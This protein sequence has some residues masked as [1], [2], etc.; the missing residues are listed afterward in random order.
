MIGLV[1]RAEA[2]ATEAHGSAGQVRKYTGDPYIV[3]PRAVVALVRSVSHSDEQLA[4][5][6]LHDVVEDCGVPIEVIRRD[7]G[8]FVSLLVSD[9]TDVSKPED[10]NREARK[11]IDRAHSAKASPMA[12]TVKLADN[13]DNM[14]SIVA[15]DPGFAVIYLK[16]KRLLMPLLRE[17]DATL[18]TM[19][20]DIIEKGL[21]R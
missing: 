10:G 9:L 5:G 13:I 11:A 20:N 4:A 2:F 15:R 3:H 6:W 8:T 16:E 19:A 21:T 12:K 14:R 17:G 7:F 18:W 1:E